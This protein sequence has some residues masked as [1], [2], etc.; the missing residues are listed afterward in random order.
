MKIEQMRVSKTWVHLGFIPK[1]KLM[2][3]DKNMRS[4]F[5]CLS[6]N[7]T[8]KT[9]NHSTS[10]D[11]IACQA[12]RWP[13]LVALH[14]VVARTFPLQHWASLS[15]KSPEGDCQLPVRSRRALGTVFLL[16]EVVIVLYPS[17]ILWSSKILMLVSESICYCINY[18]DSHLNSILLFL[19]MKESS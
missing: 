8:F 16:M 15:P 13:P 5:Q 17:F 4:D 7:K 2:Y 3:L 12:S 1:T 14:S 6:L 10:V 18:S 19:A 11:A 9:W